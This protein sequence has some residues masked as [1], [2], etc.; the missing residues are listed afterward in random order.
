MTGKLH[1]I[2]LEQGD[3]LTEDSAEVARIWV[4]DNS[5]SSV[6]IDARVLEDPRVFGYLM[7]DTIRHAARAYAGT[8]ELDENDALQAIVDGVAEE[9]SEQFGEIDTIQEGSLN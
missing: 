5:G 4:T 1:E 8:W 9:L 2:S 3:A 6:W 7:A